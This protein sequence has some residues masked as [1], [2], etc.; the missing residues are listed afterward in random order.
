MGKPVTQYYGT[1]SADSQ[2]EVRRKLAIVML[3]MGICE[4]LGALLAIYRCVQMYK[5]R[6]EYDLQGHSD[7]EALHISDPNRLVRITPRS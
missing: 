2:C 3:V 7:G 1:I 4:I 6:K 5:S